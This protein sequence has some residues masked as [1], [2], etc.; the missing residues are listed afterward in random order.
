MADKKKSIL[1]EAILNAKLIQ[2][3][4]DANTE[5]ILRSVTKEEI[6]SVVKESLEEGDYVVEDVDT[7]EIEGADEDA[8]MEIEA[9]EGEE[10]EADVEADV[11]ADMAGDVE[12]METDMEGDDL[13]GDYETGMDAEIA[14]D[15]EVEMDMTA[16]SDEDVIAVYKKLTGD[17]EIEVVVD[18]E[19]GEVKLS[20]NE[21]GEFVIK[22]GAGKE[23]DV[24]MGE[25]YYEESENMEEEEGEDVDEDVMYE[26]ALD[27]AEDV[28]SVKAPLGN[29]NK[30]N[31]AGDNLEGGFEED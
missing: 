28:E 20:V 26:I 11:E 23:A 13:E 3:A 30:D 31:F 8:E 12:N 1:E 16:A 6:N 21:P 4:L 24:E 29:K 25:G 27:E 10:M 5:E 7:E 17:D 9:P 22:T 14:S 2:E 18:D 19:A 15:D